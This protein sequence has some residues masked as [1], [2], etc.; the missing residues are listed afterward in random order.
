MIYILFIASLAL[1]FYTVKKIV[2]SRNTD[3]EIKKENDNL[4]K[5]MKDLKDKIKYLEMFK[6]KPIDGE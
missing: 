1:N 5:E 3:S 6:Q 4:I 2:K